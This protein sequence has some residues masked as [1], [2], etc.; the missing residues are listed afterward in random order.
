L[1]A[2]AA[3]D[4]LGSIDVLCT[5]V[6][7]AAEV[8]VLDIDP[9]TWRSTVAL[10]LDATF[11]CAQAFARQFVANGHGSIVVIS[12]QLSLAVRLGL[13]HYG[14][15][16]AGVNHLV[17]VMAVELAPHAV[18]VNAIA[19]GPIATPMLL[20]AFADYPDAYEQL[21][22]K[23]PLGR[24][25]SPNDIANAATFLASDE[26]SFVTGTTLVADGGYVVA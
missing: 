22:A 8:P 26:S 17:R 14:A 4:R 25:G 12:S 9:K 6:G 1:L 24:A 21:L 16:K 2:A 19:P 23:I 5:T 18:R 13:A 11:W 20:A 7:G 15:A 3:Q 10:N